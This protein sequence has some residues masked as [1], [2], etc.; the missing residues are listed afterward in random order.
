[1]GESTILQ[2]SASGDSTAIYSYLW[3]P[4]SSLDN[5]NS[6]NPVAT[7][8]STTT[9]TLIASTQYGCESPPVTVTIVVRPT[10]VAEA[11]PQQTICE[12]DSVQ[13]MGGYYYTTTDSA[14]P[15][16]IYYAWT[17]GTGLLSDSTV[18]SPWVNPTQSGFYY[19]EVRHNT[20][21]T[22]DSVLVTVIPGLNS[23]VD[24]DT[25]ITC[26]GGSVQ[27]SAGGGLGGA[28][29]Q[30]IPAT[31]L[32]DPNIS[33]P[34]ATPGTSTVY[35]VI[36]SEGGCSDT[37][38]VPLEILP[39]PE[40]AILSSVREGCPD[41]T[42]SFL[43]A[44]SNGIQWVW[45]FGDGQ[46]SNQQNPTHT[47][48][49]PGEYQVTLTTANI[50]G[51]KAAS[52]PV[53]IR[54]A[55]PG[56]AE[57]T[58]NPELPAMVSLPNTAIQFLDQSLRPMTWRWEFGDG[59]ESAE[60]NPVH[61]YNQPGE[62]MITLTTTTPE[63]CQTS[64]THGPVVVYTP[65]L[66]IPNVFTPNADGVNDGFLVQY[67]GSQ[68]FQ[69]NIYDRWGV[70]LF[71]SKNKTEAWDGTTG[72]GEAVAEGTYYYTVNIGGKDYTGNVTLMR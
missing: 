36:I 68:P 32:S 31:G 45:N 24:A 61:A 63:G 52:N 40:A 42:V 33:N 56:Q 46:I 3:S 60:Q 20:C 18:T 19:L 16:Q 1:L 69:I 2:G 58:A 41:F 62:Y 34:V 51:C 37:L 12:G 47:Y 49:Q 6:A 27:L 35:S 14:N 50:G 54:V 67:T 25:G 70:M 26:A 48:S 71:T 9:Y 29:Y 11:G 44:S 43:D 38:S 10:P 64:V 7:P 13:L 59:R 22:L 17:P 5:P 15:S 39:M 57:F 8:D 66:F 28:S 53:I 30:W 4:A 21:H 55:D 72:K 23:W 65:D